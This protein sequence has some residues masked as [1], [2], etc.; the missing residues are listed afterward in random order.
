MFAVMYLRSYF[1]AVGMDMYFET[2]SILTPL[3]TNFTVAVFAS[4]LYYHEMNILI[5]L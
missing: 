5:S 2:P 3:L 4:N 1:L